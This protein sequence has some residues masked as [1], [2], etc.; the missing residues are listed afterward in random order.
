MGGSE[1]A[2]NSGQDNSRAAIGGHG[3]T[4]RYDANQATLLQE[5]T[6]HGDGFANIKYTGYT[7]TEVTVITNTSLTGTTTPDL[8][9]SCDQVGVQTCQCKITSAT[10]S[11]SPIWTDVTNFVTTS[12]VQQN[13]IIIAAIGIGQIASLSSINLSNGDY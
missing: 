3:G 9:I 5:W 6:S 2:G 4:S 13:N 7:T 1:R 10:A 11:N 8:H 12:V